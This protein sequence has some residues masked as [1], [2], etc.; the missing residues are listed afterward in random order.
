MSGYYKKDSKNQDLDLSESELIQLS[1]IMNEFSDVM[2]D[3]QSKSTYSKISYN[4]N[5]KLTKKGQNG[6][7]QRLTKNAKKQYARSM[8]DMTAK[9]Y[10]NKETY[11][12]DKKLL[13][14]SSKALLGLLF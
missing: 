2:S 5:K 7:R 4:M 10:K 9:L 3:A 1:N 14:D 11:K 13:T 12:K 6:K 8:K